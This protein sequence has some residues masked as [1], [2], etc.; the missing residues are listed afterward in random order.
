MADYNVNMKQWNG[1]SF[2]N[3]LP[4][5]YNSKLLDGQ[6]IQQIKQWGLDNGVLLYTGAYIGTGLNGVNNPVTLSFPFKPTVIILPHISK[7]DVVDPNI[8]PRIVLANEL[9]SADFSYAFQIYRQSGTSILR[10]SN[11]MKISDDGRSVSFYNDSNYDDAG[12]YQL[13]ILGYKYW[14]GAIGGLDKGGQD[15]E[16]LITSDTTW[17]VP[18]TGRYILE[19]Y[20]GGG[21]T[22]RDYSKYAGYGGGSSCQHYDSITLTAGDQIPVTIGALGKSATN[23]YAVKAGGSTTFGDYSVNGGGIGTKTEAGA[24]AGNYGVAGNYSDIHERPAT[25]ITNGVYGYVYGLGSV[26]TD[27]G[28]TATAGAVYLK[29]LG[30]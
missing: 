30:A 19:L 13:N 12:W 4:L 11:K 23:S 10:A 8:V 7:T 1:S 18:K 29:Y 15:N 9:S 26:D 6:T 22:S 16:W 24:A 5:A 28:G 20:G 25:P 2:D 17:T 21:G 3:V 14:F 27:S